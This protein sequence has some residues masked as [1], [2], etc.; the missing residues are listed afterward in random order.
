MEDNLWIQD[1]EKVI[2][3]EAPEL[4]HILAKIAKENSHRGT[5]ARKCQ[6]KI[7]ECM[8]SVKIFLGEIRRDAQDYTLHD[9]CHSI[10]VISFMGQLL[11]NLSEINPAEISFFIYSALFHDIGMVKLKNETIS[12]EDV[13][14]NH[15][16]RSAEFIRNKIIL[17]SN[18]VPLGFGEWEA[19]YM[20]Y[21]PLICASH[22]QEFSCVEKL[23]R[24]YM[25]DGME[26]DISL[27]AILLRLA[28]AMDLNRNRAPY[29]LVR[30][31]EDRSVSPTH[32]QKHMSIT[33]CQVDE[34][35][36]YRV[37]GNCHDELTHRCLYNH[38]DM[39]ELEIEKVFRWTNGPHPRLR[40]ESHL[41]N[42]NINPNGY[43][44]WN[45]TFTMD[46]LKI[47][48]L[49]MGEQ[50]YGD[51]RLGFREIIQ[52]SLDACFVRDEMNKSLGC[53][54]DYTYV[55]QI[56]II[57]DR[58][59][60]QAIIRDNGTGMNDYIIRNYFLNIGASFYSSRDFDK[61]NIKYSPAGYFGIG[62]LA[63]F[64][65]SDDVYVKTSHWQD[66][67]EYELHFIKN[68]KF[69]TKTERR[70]SFSG[71]E[72]RLNLNQFLE[73]FER[74]NSDD[75]ISNSPMTAEDNI[76][77]FLEK[78][79]WNIN[80]SWM[81]NNVILC[82]I[83]TISFLK[84]AQEA[85]DSD[86]GYHID[87]SEYLEGIEGILRLSD[88]HLYHAAKRLAGINNLNALDAIKNGDINISNNVKKSFP[89][90]KHFYTFDGN[91]R[92]IVNDANEYNM[93]I[94]FPAKDS[95]IEM[96]KT[97]RKELEASYLELS[98][99]SRLFNWNCLCLKDSFKIIDGSYI[100]FR[101]NRPIQSFDSHEKALYEQFCN[102]LGYSPLCFIEAN[103]LETKKL[104]NVIYMDNLTLLG[105]IGLEGSY[106][107]KQA[108]IK[109]SD[110][111][112]QRLNFIFF[113]VQSITMR[114]TNALIR[115]DSSRNYIINSSQELLIEAICL[116][117]LLWIYDQI[118]ISGKAGD[119]IEYVRQLILENWDHKNNLLKA[120][121]RPDCLA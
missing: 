30:F 54:Q 50:L 5:F 42:R 66:E 110:F 43:K 67:V 90:I 1:I 36:I 86:Y 72:I 74:P 31:L 81:E 111:Q 29:Q 56:L 101:I 117:V 22:M 114:I 95:K 33:N 28:D 88:G 78:T 21:L 8:E 69:V 57:F 23:P 91:F 59:H 7:L 102:F 37:D 119:S 11:A 35:G 53:S 13:R 70:K 49:F 84:F 82:S 106:W 52:N 44:I 64:M 32:W 93:F 20:E 45:H 115:P 39:I 63:C 12:V 121:K 100:E 83:K 41:V 109:L 99:L 19:V 60:N 94:F 16:D 10:N 68:D 14:E 104:H 118:K 61:L 120:E 76:I 48:N 58:D 98:E 2:G 15:G 108:R 75:F 113:Q 79:F 89:F 77:D 55:P 17:N 116:C 26:V 34:N 80:I 47:S 3:C 103:G 87:L 71:T 18:D 9:L 85:T 40:L 4:L 38:L 62:F 112:S 24:S 65:L 107:L 51:K 73:V 96:D 92:E 6:S 25:L 105:P 46:M 27:C 97:K